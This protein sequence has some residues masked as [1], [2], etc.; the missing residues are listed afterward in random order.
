MR[1]LLLSILMLGLSIS[2]ASAELI[3]FTLEQGSDGR[4]G[5]SSIH[6]ADDSTPMSG[7]LVG[8]LSGT[9]DFDYDAGTDV[10]TVVGSTV[11]IDPASGYQFAILGGSIQGNGIGSLDFELTG[12]GRFAQTS[13]ILFDGPDPVCCGAGGPNFMTNGVMRLWGASTLAQG[14]GRIGIDLGGSGAPVPEPSAALVFA[15]GL[16]VASR[17]AARRR[18]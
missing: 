4:F 8:A 17:S 18:A 6:D 10:Y 15:L 9:L 5:Y 1:T 13:T 3:R 12:A 2:P 11:A 7:P 16:L 14:D